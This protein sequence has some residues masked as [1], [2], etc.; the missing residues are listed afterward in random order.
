ME[1]SIEKVPDIRIACLKLERTHNVSYSFSLLWK[2][3]LQFSESYE[4]LQKGCKYLS[5]TLDY[6]FITAEEQSRF[7]V[8]VTLPQ[9]FETPKGFGIYEIPAGEYAIFRFKGLYHELNRVYRYIYLDWLSA[10][11]YTL[12]EPFTFE[13]YINTPNKTPASELITNIYIPVMK[14]DV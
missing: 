1:L 14:K 3:L 12:R 2:Q 13:T 9:S 5:L 4:L 8:G 11:D 10:S 6:P 7:M